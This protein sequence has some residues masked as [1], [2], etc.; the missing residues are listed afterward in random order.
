MKFQRPRTAGF[1]KFRGLFFAVAIL[2]ALML[3]VGGFFATRML[4]SDEEQAEASA[5]TTKTENLSSVREI[6][7]TQGDGET[8]ALESGPRLDGREFEELVSGLADTGTIE[9]LH[10][11]LDTRDAP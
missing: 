8:S 2:G 7:G 1:R 5:G 9:Q 10:Y 4:M 3:A 11:P 6:L